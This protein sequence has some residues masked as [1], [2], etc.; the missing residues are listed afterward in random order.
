M[1]DSRACSA[2]LE[3]NLLIRHAWK[4]TPVPNSEDAIYWQDNVQ[5]AGNY[6][7]NSERYTLWAGANGVVWIQR[8]SESIKRL[9]RL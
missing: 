5:R 1:R 4:S 2:P 7:N 6:Q 3:L 9:S 8:L